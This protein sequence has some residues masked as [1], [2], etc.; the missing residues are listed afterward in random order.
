VTKYYYYFFVG[1][2]YYYVFSH[3]LKYISTTNFILIKD[4]APDMMN[5]INERSYEKCGKMI[6]VTN[7]FFGNVFGQRDLA[8]VSF[9]PG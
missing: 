7:H 6:E 8:I 2:K 4:I 9:L 3:F 1:T 5:K